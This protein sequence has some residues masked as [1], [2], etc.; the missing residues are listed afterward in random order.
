MDASRMPFS[1]GIVPEL[2]SLEVTRGYRCIR[3]CPRPREQRGRSRIRNDIRDHRTVVGCHLGMNANG[4]VLD[5]KVVVGYIVETDTDVASSL[6]SRSMRFGCSPVKVHTR[7][8][9]LLYRRSPSCARRDS[10]CTVS[11]QNSTTPGTVETPMVEQ[12]VA[13]NAEQQGRTR[14]RTHGHDQYERS[15]TGSVIPRESD[16][17]SRS[18][19][20]RRVRWTIGESINQR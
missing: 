4:V 11:P 3:T 13:E 15:R 8:R 6:L 2:P 9:R 17:S 19:S 12:W 14:G 1:S 5:S 16:T 18:Y 20:L 10:R 7:P